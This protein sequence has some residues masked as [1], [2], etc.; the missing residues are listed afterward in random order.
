MADTVI[1]RKRTT[2]EISVNKS[3]GPGRVIRQHIVLIPLTLLELA[4]VSG[5]FHHIW[6]V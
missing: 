1:V 4:Q 6:A 5:V 2:T 3:N